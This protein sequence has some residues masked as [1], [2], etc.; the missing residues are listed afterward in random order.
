MVEYFSNGFEDFPTG[1]TVTT[2]G[3]STITK[4][5]T[6]VHSGSWACKVYSPNNSSIAHAYKGMTEA[7]GDYH[8]QC[9]LYPS[10]SLTYNLAFV[11]TTWDVSEAAP[12]VRLLLHDDAGDIVLQ[13]QSAGP[14]YHDIMILTAGQYYKI[15]CYVDVS[16][17][18]MDVYV[19][20]VLKGTFA[21]RSG[22]NDPDRVWIGATGNAQEGEYWL[23]DV[24]IDDDMTTPSVDV[25]PRGSIVIPSMRLLNE[26]YD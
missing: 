26:V 17:T 23:D 25:H 7:T 3:A 5:A 4:D 24:L 11:L 13:S 20:D 18:E 19:D 8:I 22:T 2:S 21:I 1:W 9:E 10:D 6:H 15:D 16:A 14:A 12:C